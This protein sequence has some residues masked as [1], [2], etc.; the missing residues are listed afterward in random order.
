MSA[1]PAELPVP[2]QRPPIPSWSGEFT[3]VEDWGRGVMTIHIDDPRLHRFPEGFF[4]ETD[5]PIYFND[6]E[7][8][9]LVP[10]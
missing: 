2:D 7:V 9:V 6:R 3:Y 1:Q 4:P 8:W 5:S 10:E